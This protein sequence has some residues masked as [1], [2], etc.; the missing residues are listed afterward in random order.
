MNIVGAW[1]LVVSVTAVR[2]GFMNA[3]EQMNA[4]TKRRLD[5]AKPL[6]IQSKPSN[7]TY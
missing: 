5:G 2:E 1:A 4:E 6:L 3:Y 7:R